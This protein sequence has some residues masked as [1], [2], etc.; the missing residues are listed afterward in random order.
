MKGVYTWRGNFLSYGGRLNIL[1]SSFCNIPLC[2]KNGEQTFGARS[3][4]SPKFE[5]LKFEFKCFK[6]SGKKIPGRR[7]HCILSMCNF[8]EQICCSLGFAKMTK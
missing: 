1:R 7:H 4:W 3:P 6:I 8:L 5:A 2:S